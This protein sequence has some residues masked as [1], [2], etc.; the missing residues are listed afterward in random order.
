MI[1]KSYSLFF[2][3]TQQPIG[4][5]YKYTIFPLVFF[6]LHSL[7]KLFV[8]VFF[9][10][11]HIHTIKHCDDFGISASEAVFDLVFP[12]LSCI[13]IL[14]LPA[15]GTWGPGES[16]EWGGKGLIDRLIPLRGIDR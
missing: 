11:Q 3:L 5:Q 16:I 9:D 6:P 1:L 7:Y 8:F 2:R 15:V 13:Y 10:T 12:A 4:A 14:C